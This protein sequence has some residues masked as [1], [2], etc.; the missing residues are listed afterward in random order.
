[1]TNDNDTTFQDFGWAMQEIERLKAEN[2]RL[3]EALAE[4]ERT[5]PLKKKEC[6]GLVD[7]LVRTEAQLHGC[8]ADALALNDGHEWA[9]S[10]AIK[11]RIEDAASTALRDLLA[12]TVES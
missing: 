6:K 1:M 11:L 12:P 4:Y 9:I 8:Y 10:R 7:Q 2:A 5:E 3:A